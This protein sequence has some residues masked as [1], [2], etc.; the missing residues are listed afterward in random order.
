MYVYVYVCV[1]V[2]P[3]APPLTPNSPPPSILP[4]RFV[5]CRGIGEEVEVGAAGSAR[6]AGVA[7][8]EADSTTGGGV[9]MAGAGVRRRLEDVGAEGRSRRLA[10]TTMAIARPAREETDGASRHVGLVG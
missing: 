4:G 2:F 3:V 8:E 1:C 7:A 9:L 5:C 10:A 6:P